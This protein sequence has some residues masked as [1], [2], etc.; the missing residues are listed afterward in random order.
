MPKDK[1]L[2]QLDRELEQAE[3]AVAELS[4]KLA[5]AKAW[6]DRTRRCRQARLPRPTDEQVTAA[7][8]R[9]LA[10]GP[11]SEVELNRAVREDLTNRVRSP[12][13]I[14]DH[15]YP[16]GVETGQDVPV[17]P[18]S[19]VEAPVVANV[20]DDPQNVGRRLHER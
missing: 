18:S 20:I 3:Q 17:E 12:E 6:R 8:R 5:E 19:A 7:V 2:Q 16:L 10:A 11:L 14:R 1:I 9:A 4:A 15:P 13:H